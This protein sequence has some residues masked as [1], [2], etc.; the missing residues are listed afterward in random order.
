[1]NNYSIINLLEKNSIKY[2]FEI[3][4]EKKIE[5][6]LV[7]GCVRDA[8]LDK[9]IQDIDVAIN[10]LP[11][12]IIKILNKNNLEYEDYAYKYGCISTI[13]EGQKFQITTLRED[14]NQLGRHTN[15]IFTEDWYKDAKRR[16][17][18]IN[19]IYLSRKG[20]IKDF[21][22]GI[23]D[24]QDK[25]IRFI[26]N[27]EDRIKEDYLRIFRYY[28]FLGIFE[29]PQIIE[30]YEEILKKNF[31]NSFN[32]LSN[33]IVRQEILKMFKNPFPLNSFFNGH[34]DYQEK[35]WLGITRKQFLKTKYDF[36]L[37]KCLNKINLLI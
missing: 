2:L 28:R 10:I 32:Y 14:I 3:F 13:I 35:Y 37:K 9:S 16:D 17:F 18:T 5:L 7:G 26:G 36:G 34:N 29:T 22:N 15:V 12:E 21:F 1:M 25:K 27:I 24:L 19:A 4:S 31:T 23:Y 30:I 20:T 6:C 33:E 8:L 11:N